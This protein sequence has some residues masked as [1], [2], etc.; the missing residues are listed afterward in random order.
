MFDKWLKLHA[1]YWLRV[2]ALVI[3]I[4]GVAVSNV[5]MSIGAIWIISNWLIEAK[6][7]EY[8]QRLKNSPELILILLFLGYSIL[9]VAWSDDFWYAFHDIRIKLPLLAIP[10]ALG[11]GA[12]LDRKVFH[13]LLFLFIGIVAFTSALNF[14]WFNFYTLQADIRQMSWFISQIRFAT[15]VDLALFSTVFLILE[16]KFNWFFGFLLIAWFTLYTF[17]AQVLNGYILFALLFLFT[18]IFLALRVKSGRLKLAIF[19][20]FVL[21][22]VSALYYLN[23]VFKNY[24]G[25]EQVEFRSL[26]LYTVNGNPYY[27]D[28]L[29]TQVENGQYVWLYVALDEVEKEWNERAAI[30]YDSLDQKGQPMYGTLLRYL[31]SKHQRKDSVGVWSLTDEE[32]KKV[33]SGVTSIEMNNG[34]EARLRSFLYEFEMYENGADPNGFSFLQRLEHLKTAKAILADHWLFGVGIGDVDAV[35]QS[36]YER[37]ASKLMPQNRLRSH[38]QFLSAWIALGIAGLVITV[39][40]F[41]VPV[42]QK[43]KRDYFLGITIIA[44]AVAFGF[45]DML[46]T[47]AGATIFALFYS[48]A[49][50]RKIEN[51]SLAAHH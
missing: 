22:F 45:E 21:V 6:F 46:E 10:L 33:E 43:S 36:Y 17:Y 38:N 32:I 37:G 15:L 28:T 35:F 24:K 34:L 26:D 3:L 30:A 13:F 29:S 51:A 49:V 41:I 50:F 47:Q 9:T 39:L 42:F 4:I 2:T 11:S 40:L 20:F 8:G 27:H 5:L 48:L 31:T 12:P 44:L 1:H 14:I 7:S 23:V 16:K 25:P 19:G 18:M